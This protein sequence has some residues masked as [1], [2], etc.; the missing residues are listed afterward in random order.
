MS[1]SKFKKMGI[2]L[3]TG[4]LLF[5]NSTPIF[6]ASKCE[7]WNVYKYAPSTQKTSH[8]V[9]LYE[10]VGKYTLQCS[11]FSGGG[12]SRKIKVA[13][14]THKVNSGVKEITAIGTTNI[15][16]KTASKKNVNFTLTLQNAEYGCSAS[17]KMFV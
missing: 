13:C 14:S 16:I 15:S 6:A 12:V 2:A 8:I 11:S 3:I 7:S 4:G 17:R 1:I 10:Y 5:A 9:S